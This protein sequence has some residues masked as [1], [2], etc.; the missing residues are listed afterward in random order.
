MDSAQGI[1]WDG[2]NS[3]GND[4]SLTIECDTNA[5]LDRTCFLVRRGSNSLEL[6]NLILKSNRRAAS[7]GGSVVL[8]TNESFGTSGPLHGI[9]ITNCHLLRGLHGILQQGA[10]SSVRDH[11]LTITK[12]LIGG[13]NGASLLDNLA[14]TGVALVEFTYNVLVDEND[15]NGLAASGRSLNGITILGANTNVVVTRN[16][17]HNIVALGGGQYPTGFRVANMPS[18]GPGIKTSA[19]I[20]NNMVY[21]MHRFG[22]DSVQLGVVG[23]L[24]D[25][26]GPNPAINSPYG[27]GTRIDWVNNTFNFNILS[28]EAG[29]VSAIALFRYAGRNSVAGLSDSI[30]FLNNV[31]SAYDY[32]P[33]QVRVMVVFAEGAQENLV[34]R[35]NYNNFFAEDYFAQ[36]P[37]PWPS[38][39]IDPFY[40]CTLLSDWQRVTGQDSNSV[41]SFPG[42]V[43]PTNL[44]IQPTL[45]FVPPATALGTAF[46]GVSVD[47]DNQPRDLS[48]PDAGADEFTFLPIV[49][50]LLSP[51]NGTFN[52]PNSVVLRWEPV[53]LAS[54]YRVQLSEDSSFSMGLLLDDSTVS[55]TSQAVIGLANNSQFYWRVKTRNVRGWGE[56]TQTWRF[57]TNIAPPQAQWVQTNGPEGGKVWRLA[58]HNNK[59]YACTD[60]G[61]FLS[62]NGGRTWITSSIGLTTLGARALAARGA[63]MIAGTWQGAFRSADYGGNWNQISNGLSQN[64]YVNCLTWDTA[65]VFMGCQPVIGE[66]G[67]VFRSADNGVSWT[68]VNSGLSTRT[69]YALTTKGGYLLAGTYLN[70]VFRSSDGGNSWSP[71]ST[72][73]PANASGVSFGVSGQHLLLGTYDG[74][75]LSTDFGTNWVSVNTGLPGYDFA[76]EFAE[77]GGRVLAAMNSGEVI[78]STD[79]G[80]TWNILSSSVA[81]GLRT[82]VLNGTEIIVGATGGVFLSTDNGNRWISSIAGLISNTVPASAR[83]QNTLYAGTSANGLYRS[84]NRGVTWE[85]VN[86]GPAQ[87]PNVYRLG[88]SGSNLYADVFGWGIYL[89][90][91]SGASWSN[92]STNLPSQNLTELAVSGPNVYVCISSGGAYKTTN[93]GVAWT[94]INTGLPANPV[95]GPIAVSGDNLFAYAYENGTST[96]GVFRSTN[97]GESWSLSNSGLPGLRVNTLAANGPNVFAGIYSSFLPNQSGVYCSTDNGLSWNQSNA[98][99]TNRQANVFAFVGSNVL[100]GT[101]N[102]VFLSNNNGSSWQPINSGLTIPVS[103]LTIDSVDIFTG[104]MGAGVWR[105]PLA[106]VIPL[107]PP[108]APLHV[109]PANGAVGQQRSLMLVWRRSALAETYGLQVAADTTFSNLVVNDSSLTDTNRVA[110]NLQPLTWYYW[111]VNARNSVGTG[112]YSQRWSF[113]TSDAPT[114]VTLVT[115]PNNA[116]NQPVTLTFRWQRAV[117]Q[118][119]NVEPHVRRGENT[120]MTV[121]KQD[122]RADQAVDSY[123]DDLRISV[124]D[125]VGSARTVSAYWFEIATDTT[126]QPVAR[127]TSLTDTTKSVTGLTH[128]SVYYW[129]VKAKNEIGWGSFSSRW[130]LTTI[131][132]LPSPVVLMFPANNATVASDSVRFVW[133]RSQPAVNRYWHQFSTDSLFAL[134]QIDSTI[135]DTSSIAPS[136]QNNTAYFWRVRAGN[137]A[138]WGTFSETWRFSIVLTSLS[139]SGALPKQFALDQNYP[140]PFNPSTTI[141]FAL[142]KQSHVKLEVFNV[143]GQRIAL[144]T[145]EVRQAGYYSVRFNGGNLASGVYIYRLQAGTFLDTKKTVLLK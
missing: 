29:I 85:T 94:A 60:G 17:I 41:F 19:L 111:R 15:I 59:L 37:F 51:L 18:S 84:D 62:P 43:S 70:G 90:T 145:N 61:M 82:I 3:S 131:P 26:T 58:F 104:T 71:A 143:L 137:A 34:L 16:M 115:P 119:L 107:S 127:D 75:F 22:S 13:G 69:I 68:P 38:G 121:S 42:Y 109:T 80:N 123:A 99:L 50:S 140:N 83:I 118:T 4:Q 57:T 136:L 79:N 49:P 40:T 5:I 9:L 91:S 114:Q 32:A 134:S 81:N 120:I 105:R 92:I 10:S 87:S 116:V 141:K 20:A 63:V 128:L 106:E 139:E 103:S 30:S 130:K 89:S 78:S 125:A 27:V 122:D 74:V 52:L 28:S 126:G 142:P 95:V 144:L 102:G 33:F 1:I 108:M 101:V 113:K 88:A 117:D 44:H 124:D 8:L 47:I 77:G 110:S 96:Q 39:T 133:I 54:S 138:G 135:V 14:G 97:A 73:L 36:V 12:N 24:Y 132:T 67:G 98:G 93:N 55:T 129:R 25:P 66:G 11:D 21:D 45:W 35:S 56:F 112:S 23:L 72:G 64:A 6:K 100:L 86:V 76:T 31:V 65:H 53:V 48:R 7:D 46:P 2:S